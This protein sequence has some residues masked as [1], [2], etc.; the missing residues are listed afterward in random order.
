MKA[1]KA[2]VALVLVLV[3]LGIGGGVI[4]Y[5]SVPHTADYAGDDAGKMVHYMARWKMRGGETL[6]FGE[7]VSATVTG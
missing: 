7:R 6:A 3:V 1:G 2:V 4:W 5:L